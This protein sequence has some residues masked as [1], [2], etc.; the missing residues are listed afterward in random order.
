MLQ[1]HNLNEGGSMVHCTLARARRWMYLMCQ[2]LKVSE[3]F[4]VTPLKG[5]HCP[6]EDAVHAV[7]MNLPVS[8]KF[9]AAL[10]YLFSISLSI[11]F[12]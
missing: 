11:L 5:K 12:Y 4:G 1:V 8:P 2:H 7:V 9:V 6:L 3:N 10:F